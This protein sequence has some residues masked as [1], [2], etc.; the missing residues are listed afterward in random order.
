MQKIEKLNPYPSFRPGQA[1]TITALLE[2]AR[3]GE[4]I[5]ELNSPTGTGK[6]IGRDTPVVMYDGSLKMSQDIVAGD[7]LMGPDSFPRTVLSISSGWGK[8]Y[9]ITPIRGGN[10]F[11]CNGNHILSLKR[12]ND[13]TRKVGTICNISIDEY[14]KQSKTFKHIHKLWHSDAIEFHQHNTLDIPPYLLGLWLGDGDVIH[15]NICN[16]EP[17]IEAYINGY[18][19]SHGICLTRCDK[20]HCPTYK[21]NNQWKRYV[22][23]D[24]LKSVLEIC[25]EKCIPNDYLTS[26]VE[27][28]LELLAGLLDTDGY[29]Y[30]SGYEIIAK[31]DIL[32]NDIEFLARSLGISVSRSK[33]VGTIKKLNFSGIY[34]RLYLSGDALGNVPCKVSRKIAT[35][36]CQ[37]KDALVSGFKIESVPDGEFFGFEIDQDNLFLLGDFTVTHNSLMLT[38]FCRAL[39]EENDGW[40]AIYCSPQKGLVGQLA[41][42]ERLGIV[43]LLG[44]GN[45]ACGKAKSGLAVDCPIPTRARRKTCPHCEYQA[46]K[47]RFLAADLGAATLDKILVDKSIHKP[48]LLIIDESQGLEEK[49]IN[50]SEIKIPDAVDTND[51]VESSNAWIR[52]IEMEIMKTSTKLEKV[53]AGLLLDDEPCEAT[54]IGLE[55]AFATHAKRQ[56]KDLSD[57]VTATKLAK[58]LVRFERI[59]T[60]AQGV[61]R[62]AE[63][64][65]DS[66]IITKDRTF[67][68]MSGRQAFQEL[69]MNVEHVILASGTPNTQ[70]L[71]PAGYAQVIAPHP[72][73]VERRMVYF[74]PCG[75]MNVANR[76]A[77]MEIMGAK[78]AAL[79]KQHRRS[80][81]VHCH[82]YPIADHLG[83]IIYDEGVRCKWVERKDREGSIK[84][85]METED[86]CLM[87]VACEEGLDLA[88]EKYPLNII[89]KIP[90]GFRGDD[91]MLAREAQD[92]PLQNDLHYE[93]V[94]VATAIQQA[95]GRCTR[96]PGDWSETYIMDSSFEQFYRRNHN[97]FQQWFKDALRRK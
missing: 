84:A 31:N 87:A 38:V 26:S 47:D 50:Q 1:A 94:R 39:I 8:L 93:D 5:I 25:G 70:L 43:S 21:I 64:A 83:N 11:V 40:N 18:V 90:F 74:S 32:A 69:I 6:C 81:I 28:R 3:D 44:R 88:G 4:K 27:N 91:W 7:V 59:L 30:N 10:S 41:R 73:E 20:N 2:K 48:P 82:S 57:D 15:F 78:I 46:Q 55:K 72:I 23:R 80:T 34:N 77:T 92:K 56:L 14:L 42:D 19:D 65:P 29:Y 52:R 58:E 49:L 76:D 35:K 66:F 60:K 95:A 24:Y 12:T 86:T 36:R 67:R 61:R 13:G 51:L 22:Y 9:K 45:Y 63:E 89:A 79:H 97:L 33:K 54:Q 96:G 85:W 75:K 53:F 62:M 17:E 16:P 68:M 37:K 71:A